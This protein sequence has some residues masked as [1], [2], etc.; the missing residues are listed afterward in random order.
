[1]LYS[2][3]WNPLGPVYE[4]LLHAVFSSIV[5]VAT[6]SKAWTVFARSNAGIVGWNPTHNNFAQS[7]KY[8]GA[9]PVRKNRDKFVRSCYTFAQFRGDIVGM[10]SCRH[11]KIEENTQS[12]LHGYYK[13]CTAYPYATECLNLPPLCG[14]VNARWTAELLTVDTILPPRPQRT[15]FTATGSEPEEKHTGYLCFHMEDH[16]SGHWGAG[17]GSREKTRQKHGALKAVKTVRD[18][19][20]LNALFIIII[21]IIIIRFHSHLFTCK[22]NSPRGQLQS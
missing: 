22:L 7:S 3:D 14:R 16:K 18:S 8:S 5:T 9:C 20:I 11:V 10:L 13:A 2:I 21:I 17:W 1:V 12:S 4:A 6:R 19:L 15:W